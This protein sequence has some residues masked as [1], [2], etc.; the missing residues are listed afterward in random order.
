MAIDVEAALEQAVVDL[1]RTATD[2]GGLGYTALQ[3]GR[4]FDGR[5]PPVARGKWYAAVWSD[6]AVQVG[7]NGGQLTAMDESYSLYVTITQ[8]LTQPSDYWVRHRDELRARAN[9]VKALLAKDVWSN[10]ITIAANALADLRRG[11]LAADATQAVGLIR[12]LAYEGS[13]PVTEAG[14]DWLSA[15]PQSGKSAI[16]QRL[17]FGGAM[18]VQSLANVE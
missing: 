17:K 4:Q 18:R 12:G 7:A 14:A 3:C 8:E 6:H 13:D 1:M 2:S 11:D 5:P 15:D 9:D 10:A 16:Y